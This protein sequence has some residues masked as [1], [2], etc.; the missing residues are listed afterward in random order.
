MILG[1]KG[2]V[3]VGHVC[4]KRAIVGKGDRPWR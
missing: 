2:L 3:Q 1:A 4:P